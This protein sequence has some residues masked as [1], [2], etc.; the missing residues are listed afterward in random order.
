MSDIGDAAA[1]H[2][3][4]DAVPGRPGDVIDAAIRALASLLARSRELGGLS[5]GDR[6]ELRRMDPLGPTLPAA[7]W[8]LLVGPLDEPVA[9]LAQDHGARAERAFAILITAM[10]EAGSGATPIGVALADSG[11]A[12]PRFVRLLRARGREEVAA[13]A[14]QAARWCG[15]KG[16]APAFVDTYGRNGFGRFILDAALERPDADAR[17]QAI[18]RDFYRTLARAERATTDQ[19]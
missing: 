6:A 11:Y 4:R 16:T 18:A 10:T 1:N 2:L 15:V 12:E 17:G 8:R 9:A 7:C 14:R 5:P 13:A 19:E 3:T